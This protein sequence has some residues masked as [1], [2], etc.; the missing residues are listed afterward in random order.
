MTIEGLEESCGTCGRARGDHTL[1]ELAKCM[2]TLTTDLAFEE[3]PDD[4]MAAEVN[5]RL[6]EQFKLDDDLQT[7]DHVVVK[8]LQLQNNMGVKMPAL[9]HEF[10]IGIAGQGPQ[11]VCKVLYIGDPEGMRAYGLLARDSAN[12]A[13]NAVER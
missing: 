7:A 1:R 4:A 10:Q 9:L 13:A 3:T 2:G 8:A 11:T 5:R 12:G 6:R